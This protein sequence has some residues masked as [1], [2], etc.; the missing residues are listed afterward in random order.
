MNILIVE[1]EV[2]TSKIL[3]EILK[4][5]GHNIVGIC[6]SSTDVLEILDKNNNIDLIF[7]DINIKGPVDGIQLATMIKISHP[8]ISCVFLTAHK[9]KETI[10]DAKIAK[11][12]GY[13]I[14]PITK[15]NIEAILMVTE[16]NLPQKTTLNS[17]LILKSYEYDKKIKTLYQNN[18][19]IKLSK[20]E[21]KCIDFLIN[22]LNSYVSSEQLM[23]HIW[24]DTNKYTS[25]RELIFRIRKKL[26]DFPLNNSQNF[27][28]IITA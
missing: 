18:N 14:K 2:I 6:N 4:Q 16:I 21:L 25:L 11:P 20:N 27:G 23:Y 1:D 17:K 22:K 7:M 28:Y 9:D 10:N 15:S 12:T 24:E 26:P 5:L 19:I 13:L 3:E 8:F